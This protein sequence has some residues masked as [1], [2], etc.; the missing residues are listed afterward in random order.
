MQSLQNSLL[1]WN[2]TGRVLVGG[3]RRASPVVN[4]VLT[5]AWPLQCLWPLPYESLALPPGGRLFS[6]SQHLKKTGNSFFLWPPYRGPQ[7]ALAVETPACVCVL[8]TMQHLFDV[9]VFRIIFYFIYLFIFCFLSFPFCGLL[10]RSILFFLLCLSECTRFFELS[11]RF[12]ADCSIWGWE[13]LTGQVMAC[14]RIN[15]N[16]TDQVRH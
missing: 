15:V 12:M 11:H 16:S 14:L 6:I 4:T 2:Y 8:K 13:Y 1:M 7:N 5:R 10:L 3:P 9:W